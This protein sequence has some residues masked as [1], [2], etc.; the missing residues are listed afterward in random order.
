MTL[1]SATRRCALLV[2]TFL[3]AGCAGASAQ[4]TMMI[5]DQRGIA[6]TGMGEVQVAADQATLNFAVETSATT[7]QEAARLNAETMERVIAALVAAGIP[8]DEIE[9]SNFS[10]YPDYQHDPQAAEPRIRGYRV[11][12]Q[13]SFETTDL[14]RIGQL[15]DAALEAGANRVDGISFGLSD[16]SAAEAEALRQAVE[17]ARASAQTL[18]QA[19]GVPLGEL[20]YAT[21]SSAPV[22]PLPVMMARDVRVEAAQ[23]FATPIQPGEQTVHANVTLIFAIGR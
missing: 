14:E 11:N 19:L 21:T 15:I 12:N 1:L 23:G 4:E 2:L 22:R 9:T 5:G 7:S 8:R 13:V 3:A 6:V 20:L 10:V 17:K 16:P 18:A